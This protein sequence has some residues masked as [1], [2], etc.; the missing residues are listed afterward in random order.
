MQ[1]RLTHWRNWT[2]RICF[3]P[4]SIFSV[5]HCVS[6]ILVM[7]AHYLLSTGGGCDVLGGDPADLQ[8]RILLICVQNNHLRVM[9]TRT[10]MPPGRGLASASVRTFPNQDDIPESVLLGATLRRSCLCSMEAT[11]DPFIPANWCVTTTNI[12][13]CKLSSSWF[14][15]VVPARTNTFPRA[16]TQCV[17][18]V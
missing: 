2:Y 17:E 16:A 11:F 15:T 1:L 9:L 10:I 12:S 3:E 8:G 13:S 5:C 6:Q 18:V 7:G 14:Y 4:N